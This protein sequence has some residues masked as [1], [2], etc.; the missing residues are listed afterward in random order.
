MRAMI[1]ILPFLIAL[2]GLVMAEAPPDKRSTATQERRSSAPLTA[3]EF[4]D[5]PNAPTAS[6][7]G[8]SASQNDV[9]APPK[10]FVIERQATGIDGNAE[11]SDAD[12]GLDD[13][14]VVGVEPVQKNGGLSD[15]STAAGPEKSNVVDELTEQLFGRDTADSIKNN[16]NQ[17]ACRK[18]KTEMEKY[19]N[20]WLQFIRD[21]YRQ[22]PSDIVELLVAKLRLAEKKRIEG[23]ISREEADVLRAEAHVQF[24]SEVARRT[25]LARQEERQRDDQEQQQRRSERDLRLREDEYKQER[26]RRERESQERAKARFDQGLRDAY[27]PAT[28][29]DCSVDAIGLIHCTTR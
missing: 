10:G 22:H 4:L 17:Q 1:L 26:L 14:T 27:R 19:E 28:Q 5:L 12:V 29:T 2:P 23:K 11:L 7:K 24:E 15:A 18:S 3:E 16:P 21:I 6:E 9:P 13:W 25:S 20:C 8:S